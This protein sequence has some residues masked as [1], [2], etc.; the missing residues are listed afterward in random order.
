ME[1]YGK[2]WKNKFCTDS[3]SKPMT[4]SGKEIINKNQK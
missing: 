1:K 3:N 4:I 2:I